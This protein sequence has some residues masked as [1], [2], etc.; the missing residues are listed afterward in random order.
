MDMWGSQ[1]LNAWLETG[2]QIREGSSNNSVKIRRHFKNSGMLDTLQ[3]SFNITDYSFNVE[4]EGITT[5]DKIAETV[6]SGQTF[7]SL[8]EIASLLNISKVW[9]GKLLKKKGVEKINGTYTIPEGGLTDEN[10]E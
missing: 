7:G 2:W 3:L 8:E 1:F 4:A 6:M 5:A 9:A 10:S